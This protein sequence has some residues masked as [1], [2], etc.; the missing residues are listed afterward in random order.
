MKYIFSNQVIDFAMLFL[1][2]WNLWI[3]IFNKSKKEDMKMVVKNIP[4]YIRILFIFCTNVL[5]GA[6][7]L[8]DIGIIDYSNKFLI[9]TSAIWG[10]WL[11]F[12]LVL[13]ELRRNRAKVA[14]CY[15]V[16]DDVRLIAWLLL[17]LMLIFINLLPVP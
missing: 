17:G 16:K 12:L 2:I 11:W 13:Y 1:M 6:A 10:G 8:I 9:M 4:M 3:F 15:D 7:I 14:N 5:M